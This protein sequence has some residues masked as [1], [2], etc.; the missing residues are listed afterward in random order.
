MILTLATQDEFGSSKSDQIFGFV[1][2]HQVNR[3]VRYS[4]SKPNFRAISSSLGLSVSRSNLSR[5]A[6]VDW[7]K[8]IYSISDK[9]YSDNWRSVGQGG[10]ST[11][12]FE[13]QL[14]HSVQ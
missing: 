14:G 12:Q 4:S 7:N 10:T 2:I 9:N 6:S 11:L 8:G 3:P 13:Q 1:C 5:M